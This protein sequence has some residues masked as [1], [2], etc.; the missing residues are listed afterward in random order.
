MGILI[1]KTIT[2]IK[3]ISNISNNT[4]IIINFVGNFLNVI[5]NINYFPAVS[6]F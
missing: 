4:I 6:I 3:N 1:A 2:S 5:I